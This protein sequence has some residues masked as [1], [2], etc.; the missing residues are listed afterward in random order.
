[1]C[2]AR[3]LGSQRNLIDAGKEALLQAERRQLKHC[4]TPVS[5]SGYGAS[6]DGKGEARVPQTQFTHVRMTEEPMER[7]E[8]GVDYLGQARAPREDAVTKT[9]ER[10]TSAIPSSAF[11]AIGLASMALSLA[12]QLAGR[13]KWGNF[14]GQWVPTWLIIGLYNKLVKV[15][16]HDM[17]DRAA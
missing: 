12:A 14:I 17:T 13:G 10:Y 5:A 8:R 9:I 15:Q 11:L 7:T 4:E 1:M 6:R 2:V 16:G 3:G